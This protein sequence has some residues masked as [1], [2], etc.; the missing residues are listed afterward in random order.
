MVDRGARDYLVA[1]ILDIAAS[2]IPWKQIYHGRK[3]QDLAV[4]EIVAG[5]G[6]V[7]LFSDTSTVYAP[8]CVA[9]VAR[10]VAFLKTDL[11][12]EWPKTPRRPWHDR[13]GFWRS[14]S[15]QA[16]M[17]K[18]SE[19]GDISCYPFFRQADYKKHIGGNGVSK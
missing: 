18:W 10:V 19:A 1:L 7:R 5:A 15:W 3:S 4:S 6:L 12:Y 16:K 14:D 17:L 11:E 2:N 13:N 9:E 8:Y